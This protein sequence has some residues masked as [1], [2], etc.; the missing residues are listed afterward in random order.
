MY[1]LKIDTLVYPTSAIGE[2]NGRQVNIKNGLPDQ[3]VSVLINKVRRNK[4]QARILELIAP[5]PY[6]VK[7]FCEHFGECGGC[8]RQTVPYEKQL[9]LKQA[10][11]NALYQKNGIEFA[12]T[13]IIPSPL[14]YAYRN[15]MEYSFG[16]LEKGGQLNLGMHRKGRFYDVVSIPHCHIVDDDF[17]V[18]TSAVEALCRTENWPKYNRN[19]GEGIMRNLVVRKGHFTGEILVGLA[20]SSTP[21]AIEKVVETLLNLDLKGKIVGIYHLINDGVADVVKAQPDDHL[22]Y[23]RDYFY[24]NICGLKFKVSFHSFFQTNSRGAELLYREALALI[25]QLDDKVVYD[26]FSGTGTIA[27]IVAARAKS[28]YAIE[29]VGDAVAAAKQNAEING[30]AN[31][32]FLAGDV[33][34]IL[35]GVSTKPDVIIVDPPRAGMTPKTVQ[36]IADYGVDQ[37]LYISCNPKTMVQNLTDFF[38]RGYQLTESF[39]VDLYPHTPLVES[40]VLMEKR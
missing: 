22:I 35:D 34:K 20:T 14:I 26:L 7:S 31:C 18:I 30:I 17:N 15:K 38:A 13:K 21:F 28:V 39:L 4:G 2:I 19:T 24:E 6:E 1:Q 23:G 37:I 9:A 11:I 33:F 16:D 25:P 29:I 32:T 27:Q 36:K 12:V 5:A 10:A 3:Q 40:V 8:A